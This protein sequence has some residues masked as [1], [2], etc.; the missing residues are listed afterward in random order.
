MLI[1]GLTLG[2]AVSAQAPCNGCDV[3]L[4][5]VYSNA[6]GSVQFLVMFDTLY[7]DTVPGIAPS[8]LAGQTLAASDGAVENSFTF[9]TDLSLKTG[10]FILVGTQGFADLHRVKPDFI[11]PNGFLPTRNGSISLRPHNWY[12]LTLSYAALPTDGV[13]A[14]YPNAD[15]ESF[16]Y[17][18]TAQATN[19]A[20]RTYIFPVAEKF[21]GLWWNAPSGSESGWGIA[22]DHQGETVFAAWATYDADG[23]PTWFIMPNATHAVAGSN[24]PWYFFG[25]PNSYVGKVYRVTG[26][27][28]GA[29][30]FDPSAVTA[31]IVGTGGFHFSTN[32][33]DVAFNNGDNSGFG[34][35]NADGSVY[36]YKA[37]TR[38]IFGNPVPVCVAGG[39]PGS[40]PNFQGV[41]W[42]PAESGWGLHLTHQR[43]VVV[44]VWFT[45][46]ATGKPT[47]LVM[48]A[49]KTAL[50]TY[51]GAIYRTTGPAYNEATYDRLAVA[52]TQVGSATLTFSDRDNG[53]FSSIVDGVAQNKGITRQVF[54]DPPTV[55]N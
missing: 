37:I 39:A 34:F 3:A 55:C 8:S 26:P 48:A 30:P 29:V 44:A 17:T 18:E 50:N 46:D 15:R 36:I 21:T 23:S 12:A 20:G 6:D 51:G 27:T 47:W 25:S 28:F 35:S 10:G 41:W 31:T 42:D 5:E 2:G 13:K 49:S 45:Y 9:P 1:F 54:A 53:T 40:T 32:P 4:V 24:D 38:Q 7:A 52:G 33:D 16:E 19:N 22:V 14:L 43:D 11:V